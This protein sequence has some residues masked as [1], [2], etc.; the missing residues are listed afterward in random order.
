LSSWVV[1][2][3][4]IPSMQIDYTQGAFVYGI[5]LWNLRFHANYCI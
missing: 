1:I 4:W 5:S 2:H 3:A